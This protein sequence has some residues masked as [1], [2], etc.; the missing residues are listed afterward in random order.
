MGKSP[1][2]VHELLSMLTCISDGSQSSQLERQQTTKSIGSGKLRR[3]RGAQPT[4][5]SS[6]TH[7]QANEVGTHGY[8][9]IGC[10]DCAPSPHMSTC[11]IGFVRSRR[12]LIGFSVFFFS[13]RAIKTQTHR[14]FFQKAT[15][16]PPHRQLITQA[17]MRGSS[18]GVT[19]TRHTW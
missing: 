5:S 16:A 10:Y 13:P 2:A 19:K 4:R 15:F 11:G 18:H 14:F 17:M 6:R 9:G 3:T 8:G 1:R 7:W 12:L